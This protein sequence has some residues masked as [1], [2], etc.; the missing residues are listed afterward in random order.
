LYTKLYVYLRYKIPSHWFNSKF[1][2]QDGI[3]AKY[4]MENNIIQDGI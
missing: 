1:K 3:V 2:G 4:V